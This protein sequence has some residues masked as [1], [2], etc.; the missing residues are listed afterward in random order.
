MKITI[1]ITLETLKALV[2]YGLQSNTGITTEVYYNLTD[3]VIISVKEQKIYI[4]AIYRDKVLTHMSDVSYA[5]FLD[6]IGELDYSNND[7]KEIISNYK[8]GE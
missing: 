3:Y 2:Q 6:L 1:S 5:L 4:T 7:F 8:G